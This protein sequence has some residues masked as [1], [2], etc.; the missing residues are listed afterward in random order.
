MIPELNILVEYAA[1]KCLL[2]GRLE[3]HSSSWR[4]SGFTVS[5]SVSPAYKP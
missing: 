2:G 5:K 1:L 4:P 3:V